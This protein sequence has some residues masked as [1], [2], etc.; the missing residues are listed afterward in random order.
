MMPVISDE[1]AVI[2]GFTSRNFTQTTSADCDR[3]NE[4]AWDQIE[5]GRAR[6]EKLRDEADAWLDLQ[7]ALE[8]FRVETAGQLPE[9]VYADFRRKL[10]KPIVIT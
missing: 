9:A 7:E 2:G 3:G 1:A 5:A 10:E 4:S 8:H 6:I